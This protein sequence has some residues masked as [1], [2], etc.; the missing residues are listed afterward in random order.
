MDKALYDQI[1]NTPWYRQSELGITE[2]SDLDGAVFENME[3][4]LDLK[5][6][7]GQQ[8]IEFRNCVLTHCNLGGTATSKATDVEVE[9]SV[10]N[11]VVAR[12]STTDVCKF[13][14]CLLIDCNDALKLI[15]PPQD[16]LYLGTDAAKYPGKWI[17]SPQINSMLLFK[18]ITPPPNRIKASYMRWDVQKACAE[19]NARLAWD[20]WSV[21]KRQSYYV[22][23]GVR[24]KSA[25]E[26][27]EREGVGGMLSDEGDRLADVKLTGPVPGWAEAIFSVLAQ[28]LTMFKAM[29]PDFTIPLPFIDFEPFY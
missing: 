27:I 12:G 11:C 3:I 21:A 2:R 18:S 25:V 20:A 14:R 22:F 1:V 7:S 26:A 24:D 10:R 19:L 4:G 23:L 8:R 15:P 6:L 9:I 29:S 16:C 28:N 5:R 13:E 17:R